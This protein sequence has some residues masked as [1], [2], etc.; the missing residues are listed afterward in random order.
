M[1]ATAAGD[2][3]I[4]GMLVRQAGDWVFERKFDGYRLLAV[5]VDG[6]VKLRSRRG[7]DCTSSY[8][9]I[10]AVLEDQPYE[11]YLLDGEVVALRDG[12]ESFEQLQQ[13]SGISDATRAQASGIAVEFHAFDLLALEEVDLRPISWRR[14]RGLLVDA[15][16][17]GSTVRLSETLEGGARELLQAACEQGWEGL[18]AKRADSRYVGSRSKDWLKLKCLVRQE[19]VIAG[20][21]EPKNSRVGLGALILGHHVPGVVD[22]D[23][24]LVFAGRVGTGF[25]DAMLRSLRS[26]LDELQDDCPFEAGPPHPRIPE[27]RWVRPEL[28]CEVGFAEWTTS[29]HVRHPRYLG[30]REGADASDVGRDDM[31]TLATASAVHRS[32][33]D[34]IYF[35]AI[36]GRKAEALDHYELVA[37]LMLPEIAGRPLVQERYPRGITAASF[38]QKNRPEHA[39]EWIGAFEADSESRDRIIYP[40]VRDA[41]SLAWFANQAGL[42]FHTLLYDVG[43]PLHPTEVIFDLDPGGSDVL[44]VQLAAALLR[45]R[46]LELGLAPRVKSTGSKGVHIHVDVL[47]GEID[48]ATT[49]G[50]A[51]DL[52]VEVVAERPK[53]FTLDFNK[54]AR[55]GRLLIDVLRNGHA[56]HAAAPYSLRAV[57]E[58]AV[59]V[60]LDWDEL[61]EPDFDPRAITMRTMAAR[62]DDVGD[63]WADRE[64][65]E[66]TILEA[67]KILRSQ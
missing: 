65:P 61:F 13:R 56:S 48:F 32:N 34:R 5:S 29:G 45:T 59:A 35:P 20:F 40:V 60:P 30:L 54:K 52:A 2:D 67:A 33:P 23:R 44:R 9:E 6:D 25:D 16:E 1:L 4:D 51:H 17:F 43:R 22:G 42:V 39:P 62:L 21:T 37:D 41:A 12:R 10:V 58:A 15:F 8:P 11:N 57:P 18:I 66:T 46:L 19:F 7:V 26:T 53:D 49:R 47:D 36:D 3:E 64:A 50:F 31:P 24:R 14:R 27:A 38:Y 63:P 28:V 55:R